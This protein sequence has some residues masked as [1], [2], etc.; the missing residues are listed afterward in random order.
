M[1]ENGAYETCRTTVRSTKYRPETTGSPRERNVEGA[2]LKT[3]LGAVIGQDNREGRYSRFWL[4]GGFV[5]L[6]D[7]LGLLF[8]KQPIDEWKQGIC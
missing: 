2:G 7:C 5:I 3:S 6:L 4:V 8:G 1:R